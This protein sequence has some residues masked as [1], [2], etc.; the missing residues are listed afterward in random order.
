MLRDGVR[1]WASQGVALGHGAREFRVHM[2]VPQ[3]TPLSQTRLALGAQQGLAPFLE[4]LAS[5]VQLKN[6]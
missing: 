4:V 5:A 6:S 3:R 2:A 1:A